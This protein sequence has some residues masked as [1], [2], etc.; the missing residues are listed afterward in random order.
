MITIFFNHALNVY[1]KPNYI[2]QKIKLR[3]KY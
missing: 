3:L 1:S 2:T